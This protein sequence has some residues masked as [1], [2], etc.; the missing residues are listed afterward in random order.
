[1]EYLTFFN[2]HHIAVNN[3]AMDY[4]QYSVHKEDINE[5]DA[6]RQDLVAQLNKSIDQINQIAPFGEDN[7]L[8]EE[9]LK[10]Y[11]LL[12]KSFSGDFTELFQL[13]LESQTSFEAME[14][15]FAARKVTEQEVEVAS[16]KYL[17][18]QI[19]FAQKYNVELVEAAQNN[20]VEVL[21]RLNNYHQAVF[22]RYFKVNM[23]NNDFMDALNT[24]DTEKATKSAGAT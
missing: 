18:A 17:E 14:K 20:D 19:K 15:Y 4:L 8:K 7:S 12:L 5:I 13:K 21:N 3:V 16:K 22:L 9:A 11:Q 1:M 10:V 24:Q 6:K 23:L 2:N